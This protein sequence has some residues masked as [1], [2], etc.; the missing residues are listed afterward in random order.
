MS[1]P[2]GNPMAAAVRPREGTMRLAHDMNRLLP[3]ATV[4]SITLATAWAQPLSGPGDAARA[5]P[6]GAA[7]NKHA[8]KEADKGAKSQPSKVGR[9][10]SQR[11]GNR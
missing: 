1:L 5:A 10:P 7:P 4:A 3:I 11:S 6:A 9:K 2:R 8:T